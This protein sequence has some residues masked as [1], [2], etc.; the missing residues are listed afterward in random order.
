MKVGWQL[1]WL[2]VFKTS[3]DIGISFQDVKNYFWLFHMVVK[4]IFGSF[5]RQFPITSLASTPDS[6]MG[7]CWCETGLG[8]TVQ[9]CI[10]PC[11]EYFQQ[12]LL[13]NKSTWLS[14]FCPFCRRA[15]LDDVFW[16]NHRAVWTKVRHWRGMSIVL[17]LLYH[18][19]LKMSLQHPS[20]IG[21]SSRWKWLPGSCGLVL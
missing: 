15:S 19:P 2:T 21:V 14:S 13:L 3:R 6:T 8:S 4:I 1:V 18:S 7:L 5:T 12:V 11:Q 17:L 20:E 16:G 10:L 9:L